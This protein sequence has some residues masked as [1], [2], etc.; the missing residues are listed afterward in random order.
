MASREILEEV[1]M[2]Q[3]LNDAK[4]LSEFFNLG[5]TLVTVDLQV[6]LLVHENVNVLILSV[7]KIVCFSETKTSEMRCPFL[8]LPPPP[9]P[10]PLGTTAME[11]FSDGG[12]QVPADKETEECTRV[13]T[14]TV[15][16]E[17]DG[18]AA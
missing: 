1:M 5:S 18:L 7:I 10:Q 4:Q 9:S 8:Y 6:Y 17:C 14:D 15:C 3:G 12:E 2:D 13:L 11:A 16:G